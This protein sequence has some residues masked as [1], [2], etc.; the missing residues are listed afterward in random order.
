M[1]YS[2]ATVWAVDGSAGRNGICQFLVPAHDDVK[3]VVRKD[4][5]M[6]IQSCY[7]EWP[8]RHL[9]DD[10][11]TTYKQRIWPR[12]YP[13]AILQETSSNGRLP[14]TDAS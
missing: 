10:S 5:C 8:A 11:Q 12:S 6:L 2:T 4:E 7:G 14:S 9:S 1:W 13:V 3:A